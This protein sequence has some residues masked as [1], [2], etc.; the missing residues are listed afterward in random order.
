M[1][2]KARPIEVR[3]N[4]IWRANRTTT[5]TASVRSGNHPMEIW[6]LMVIDFV[7]IGP[8]SMLRSVAV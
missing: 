6:S 7:R 8:R 4:S 5:A 3:E 2:R 1:A